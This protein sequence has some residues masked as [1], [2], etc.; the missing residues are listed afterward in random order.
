MHGFS[1]IRS[2]PRSGW[3]CLF[4]SAF[5]GAVRDMFATMY[6]VAFLL[7]CLVP[8]SRS[9]GVRPGVELAEALASALSPGQVLRKHATSFLLSDILRPR[10]AVLAGSPIVAGHGLCTGNGAS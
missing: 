4:S 2:A 8:V 7:L 6:Q 3:S 1:K 5:L 10:A 9:L